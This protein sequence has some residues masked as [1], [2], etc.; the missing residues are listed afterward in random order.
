MMGTDRPKKEGNIS[1]RGQ[2]LVVW[3]ET[4]LYCVKRNIT[5]QNRRK[6]AHCLHAAMEQ[7]GANGGGGS[8]QT[9]AQTLPGGC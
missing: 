2:L 6:C 3:E 9:Q 8:T 1:I 4:Y 7:H 5:I